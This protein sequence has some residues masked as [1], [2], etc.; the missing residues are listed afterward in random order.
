MFFSFSTTPDDR[1]RP[2]KRKTAGIPVRGRAVVTWS[3]ILLW[4]VLISFGA[5]SLANP[6]WLRQWSQLGAQ[7]EA[8]AYKH[9]G[10][11]FLKQGELGKAAGQYRRSLEIDPNQV[12]VMI[13]L[14]ITYM[15]AGALKE[16]ERTLDVAAKHKSKLHD[17]ILFNK[18]ELAELQKKPEEAIGYYNR[19][20][21]S[22]YVDPDL[23][24]RKLGSLYLQAER[25]DEAIDAFEKTLESQLDPTLPYRE[26]LWRAM[27]TY[28]DDSVD[29]HVIE[30]LLE[31]G[32]TAE[33]LALYDLQIIDK[34]EQS[35]PEVAKTHNHLAYIYAIRNEY[36][37]AAAHYR[38][39]LRI[40]P[41]NSDAQQG[42]AYVTNAR[43]QRTLS[44]SPE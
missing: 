9:Y 7:S 18:G 30:S 43:Q 31:R 8:A 33:Q 40:W 44:E 1:K 27:D 4:G 17:L 35:D 39:S 15:H 10:D 5:I 6:S 20:R 24:N 12:G 2:V 37:A 14:A 34:L 21:G 22:V 36:D 25:Y 32:T 26:M 23:V 13:N 3:L 38:E 42:L 16:A 19:V 29:V 28:V 11:A 41:G